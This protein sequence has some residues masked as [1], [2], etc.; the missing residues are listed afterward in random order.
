MQESVKALGLT[1]PQARLLRAVEVIGQSSV[2]GCP[3]L[4]RVVS[5]WD[6]PPMIAKAPKIVRGSGNLHRDPDTPRRF[7]GARFRRSRSP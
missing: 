7:A 2:P 6:N 4:S 1:I 3:R 5:G